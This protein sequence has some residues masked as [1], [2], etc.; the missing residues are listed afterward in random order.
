[1][2]ANVESVSI[3]SYFLKIRW[4]A[5][6]EYF[7]SGGQGNGF[8][9]YGNFGYDNVRFKLCPGLGVFIEQ[10]SNGGHFLGGTAG[11]PG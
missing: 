2:F 8:T 1:M 4:Y 10:F 7:F 3:R 6:I 5:F 11:V 9:R